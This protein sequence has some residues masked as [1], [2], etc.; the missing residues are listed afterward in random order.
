M[1]NIMYKHGGF[2]QNFLHQFDDLI[3]KKK[4]VYIFIKFFLHKH[5]AFCVQNAQ[6]P[7][8]G[9]EFGM[10]GVAFLKESSYK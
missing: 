7:K 1:Q 5:V 9:K 10:E 2:F 6:F 3:E 8:R 4:L